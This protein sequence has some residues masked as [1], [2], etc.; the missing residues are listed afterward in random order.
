MQRAGQLLLGGRFAL[1]DARG[2]LG[3]SQIGHEAQDEQLALGRVELA[4]EQLQPAEIFL[5]QETRSRLVLALAAVVVLVSALGSAAPA[6]ATY[7][8]PSNSINWPG[9]VPSATSRNF[10]TVMLTACSF[11]SLGAGST[12]IVVRRGT[13]R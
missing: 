12:A 2:N 7:L 9:W 13:G 5:A 6:S 3:D 4:D 10:A 11:G 1:P 8:T